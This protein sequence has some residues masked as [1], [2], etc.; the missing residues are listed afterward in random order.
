M[1]P[2]FTLDPREVDAYAAK[3]EP[4]RE[5]VYRL[6]LHGLCDRWRLRSGKFPQSPG[7]TSCCG[8]SAAQRATAQ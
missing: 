5:L 4:R 1:T 3:L 6:A 8:A 7:A 2:S